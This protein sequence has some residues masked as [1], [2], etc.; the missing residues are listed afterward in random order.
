LPQFAED[1]IWTIAEFDLVDQVGNRV[2]LGAAQIAVL[3]LPTSFNVSGA[4]LTVIFSEGGDYDGDG[5]GDIAVFRPSTG[6]WYIVDSS[7]SSGRVFRW[8]GG[9]DIPV[10]RDYDGDGKTDI[11]VFRPSTGEW[12]IVNSS[13]SSGRVFTWGGGGDLPI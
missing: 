13:T 9:G 3:G 2:E 11:A 6:E 8:G 12:Y 7:T 4:R 10:A 5:K 1:G